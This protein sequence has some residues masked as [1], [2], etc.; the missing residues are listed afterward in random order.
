ME[1]RSGSGNRGSGTTNVTHH[2]CMSSLFSR[3][4]RNDS[5]GWARANSNV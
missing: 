5:R 2:F 4:A 3:W 1:D